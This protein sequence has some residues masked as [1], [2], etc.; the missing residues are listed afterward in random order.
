[1]KS[2]TPPKPAAPVRTI[3]LL[4]RLEPTQRKVLLVGL[5][6]FFLLAG[7]STLLVAYIA[8]E[9]QI[10]A[11]FNTPTPTLTP[12][13]TPA[14]VGSTLQ[15]GN[16][17]LNFN[18]I[19]RATDGSIN[20]PAGIPGMAYWIEDLENNNV[21][22][23][24]PTPDNL[25]LL[26]ALQDGEEA[27]LTWKNCNSA[28]Y[29][30]SAPLKG[31]PGT[32]IFSD[33]SAIGLIVYIPDST[34]GPGLMVQ[35]GMLEEIFRPFETSVP[36]SFVDVE[37]SLLKTYTSKDGTTIQVTF[38]IL[39]SGAAPGT[40]SEGDISLTPED[41]TSLALIHS[42][43]SLPQELKPQESQ[44]FTVDFPRP[45]SPTAILKIFNIEF[46]LG[47]Y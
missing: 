7:L 44:I 11:Y 31:V 38:S 6:A 41:A 14:C 16:M 34:M 10:M 21:F 28:T 5:I 29:I 39:N 33:Q 15:I 36:D 20:V 8:F 4:E 32:D 37:V 9:P 27:I 40:I 47:D 17:T 12:T 3:P 13:P 35:G 25:T 45:T 43:P 30:L 19:S 2:A 22:A 24:S 23:L 26:S 42:D 18:S 46:D 1:M